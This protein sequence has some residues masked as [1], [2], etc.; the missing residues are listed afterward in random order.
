MIDKDRAILAFSPAASLGS[1]QYGMLELEK[2]HQDQLDRW[3]KTSRP[4]AKWIAQAQDRI[5]TQFAIA[6]DL[7]SVKKQN[8][9]I[10][11]N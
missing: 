8:V 7:D 9:D 1:I 2:K 3:R 5:N 4:L 10:K 11:V 6:P